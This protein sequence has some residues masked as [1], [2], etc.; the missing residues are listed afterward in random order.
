[1]DFSPETKA[2]EAT[3]R[4]RLVEISDALHA[5][6]ADA[7]EEKHELNLESDELRNMLGVLVGDHSEQLQKWAGRAAT[8][9]PQPSPEEELEAAKRHLYIMSISRESQ[10]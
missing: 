2:A 7:F 4:R 9:P 3:V 5:L 1:M 8:K 6:P 10:G